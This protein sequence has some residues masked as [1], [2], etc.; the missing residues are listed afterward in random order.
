MGLLVLVRHGQSEWNARRVFSGQGNPDL[1]PKGIEEAK[2]AGRALKAHAIQ[3]DLAYSSALTRARKTLEHILEEAEQS[4]LHVIEDKL[5][6]ERAYGELTG[7]A[8]EEVCQQ[9]GVEQ[10]H[11]WRHS[12]NAVPPGG[13]S[14][15]MTANRALGVFRHRVLPQLS[16]GKNILISA[17][18]NTI[19]GLISKLCNLRQEETERLHIGTAQPLFFQ[20]NNAEDIQQI[21]K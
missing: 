19:R 21:Y 2:N 7:K 15:E 13:E 20:V 6:N 11:K 9:H 16:N 5:F 10:V 14:L 8:I 4:H 12:L 17:H 18:R 3:F 1:T